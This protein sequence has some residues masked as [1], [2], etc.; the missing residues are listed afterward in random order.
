MV[1]KEKDILLN[2]FVYSKFSYCPLVW[3][4]CSAKSVTKKQKKYKNE[5][6]EYFTTTF[7]MIMSHLNQIW[8]INNGSKTTM[9]P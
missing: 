7:P 8:K 2:S 6:F 5:L 4:F 1:F 9:N 3:H